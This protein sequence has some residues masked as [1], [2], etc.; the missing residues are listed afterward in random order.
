[1]IVGK[2]NAL[3]LCCEYS[4]ECHFMYEQ[5]SQMHKVFLMYPN[6]TTLLEK[7]CEKTLPFVCIYIL[8][9]FFQNNA[10]LT[11][12]KECISAENI[13]FDSMFFT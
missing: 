13:S 7:F 11:N 5:P 2:F 4:V 10:I 9:L 8:M 6:R 12:F 1:M 3:I